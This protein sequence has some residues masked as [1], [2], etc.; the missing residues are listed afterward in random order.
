MLENL[1]LSRRSSDEFT[2]ALLY[3]IQQLQSNPG[4]ADSQREETKGYANNDPDGCNLG[5]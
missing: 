4:Y 2:K 1:L 3:E 5:S